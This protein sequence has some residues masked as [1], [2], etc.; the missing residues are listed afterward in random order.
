MSG[1]PFEAFVRR[2]APEHAHIILTELEHA[3]AGRELCD[4]CD[5]Y[6]EGLVNCPHMDPTRPLRRTTD[7][8]EE[9]M[10]RAAY[11]R[12]DRRLFG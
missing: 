2:V 1:E 9:E 7:L 11:A 3:R 10:E 12:H 8:E 4:S 5:E 6:H